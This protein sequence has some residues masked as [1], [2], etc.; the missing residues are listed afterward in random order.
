VVVVTGASRG[1]GRAT[2]DLLAGRGARVVG[3]ARD[4]AALAELDA[5]TGGSSVAADVADPGS[6]E[7]IVEHALRTYGRLDGVVV[8]AGIGYVGEVARMPAAGI[9]ALVDVNLRAALLLARASLPALA[10]RPPDAD[11]RRGGPVFVSSIAAAVGVP[12]E[13]GYPATKA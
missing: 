8:N 3:V 5:G 11:G 13:S 12:G 4:A 10:A 2:G 7:R 1:I 9:A 6:A